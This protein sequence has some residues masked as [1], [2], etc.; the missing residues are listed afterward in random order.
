MIAAIYIDA[1][2]RSN[3]DILLY[4]YRKNLLNKDHSF[5]NHYI[6]NQVLQATY[7]LT[8]MYVKFLS[9]RLMCWFISRRPQF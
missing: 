6:I 8:H 2:K 3:L 1:Y 4:F 7:H 5:V 9:E